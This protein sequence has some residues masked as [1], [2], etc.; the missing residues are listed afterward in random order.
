M[1]C[2]SSVISEQGVGGR[3][4]LGSKYQSFC[5]PKFPQNVI[6]FIKGINLTHN[7]HKEAS[8]SVSSVSDVNQSRSFGV[9][10]ITT[11]PS[12][13]SFLLFS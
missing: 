2:H 1:R 9:I 4:V 12:F 7:P 13:H 10:L 8:I 11:V 3:S 5:L 6:F